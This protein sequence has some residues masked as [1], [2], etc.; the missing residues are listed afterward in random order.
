MVGAHPHI[1]QTHDRGNGWYLLPGQ[2]GTN[3]TQ[4]IIP[5]EVNPAG[6]VHTVLYAP[7]IFYTHTRI[8]HTSDLHTQL[9]HWKIKLT[10][11][12]YSVKG[13]ILSLYTVYVVV[14]FSWT[15][16]SVLMHCTV[17][18]WKIKLNIAKYTVS[19][20]IQSL[21]TATYFSWTSKGWM[22]VRCDVDYPF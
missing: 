4:C 18:H 15:S 1:M 14:Y 16:K 5:F 11:L 8:I 2:E 9:A 13:C 20:C 12:Q 10:I 21:Y 6:E 22:M 7:N 17:S 3:T 19:G